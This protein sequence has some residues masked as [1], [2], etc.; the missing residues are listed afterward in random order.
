[1]HSEKIYRVKILDFKY[2]TDHLNFLYL[3]YEVKAKNEKE[4]VQKARK[5]YMAGEDALFS[6]ELPF[7]LKLFSVNHKSKIGRE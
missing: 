6:E 3:T 1:M 7:L 5:V 2:Q 4:A